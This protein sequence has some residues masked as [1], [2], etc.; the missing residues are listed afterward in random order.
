VTPELRTKVVDWITSHEHVVNSPIYNETLLIKDPGTSEKRRVAKL[1]LEIPVRELHCNLVAPVQEGGLAE[2]R[3]LAGSIII[4]D[5]NLR[6][7]IKESIPQLRRMSS[8]HKQRCGCGTCI[9]VSSLQIS[10]NGF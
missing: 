8:R 9:I 6:I 1:L 4:S 7:I 3:D 10:L 2:S 5:S